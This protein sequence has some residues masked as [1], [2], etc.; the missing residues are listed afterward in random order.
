L[1]DAHYAGAKRLGH[2]EGYKYAHDYAGHFVSQDYLGAEKN[3]YQPTEQGVE[4]KIKERLEKWRAA[5]LKAGAGPGN[6]GGAV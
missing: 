3:Y 4:K 6:A 2:G 1:G 5:A